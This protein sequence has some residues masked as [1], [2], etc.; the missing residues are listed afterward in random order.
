[1]L[2]ICQISYTSHRAFQS[3][4]YRPLGVNKMLPDMVHQAK[5]LIVCDDYFFSYGSLK[6]WNVDDNYLY[7]LLAMS[8]FDARWF[9]LSIYSP[10][11]GERHP[12]YSI[13]KSSAFNFRGTSS[14]GKEPETTFFD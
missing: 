3:S 8:E 7:Y 1:M 10:T 6:K 9:Y 12:K 11:Y 2:A 4:R 14:S 13:S 5:C